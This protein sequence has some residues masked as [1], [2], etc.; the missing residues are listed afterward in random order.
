MR[1]KKSFERIKLLLMI[2]AVGAVMAGTH[3][4][5]EYLYAHMD[6]E[7]T[8]T[9]GK[10]GKTLVVVDSGHGGS[11]PGKVGING[12]LEKD[13]NLKISKKLKTFLEKKN[14][15]VI[16]T[17]EDEGGLADS[18]VEDMK[19]RVSVINEEKPALTV[20]IHQNSYS[21]EAIHGAQVFYYTHSAEGERAA[22]IMQKALL[23]ADP[24]NRRQ[25][26]ANDTYYML[27]RTES[28]VIIVE[29]GF[30][31]NREE[32]Q[33]LSEEAYQEKIAEA[34]SEGVLGYIR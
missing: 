28:P 23:A 5:G 31:S 34:V 4:V 19:K 24:D 2:I 8:E 13:V 26:K 25:P 7:H 6:W 9:A 27:R 21:Q 11:D 17:R 16:M 22:Q 3:E 12:V 32:A 1:G 33:R 29:C 10:I 14:V 18:K 15:E 30:L 20:S